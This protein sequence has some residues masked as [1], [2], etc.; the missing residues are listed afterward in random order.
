MHRRWN[1]AGLAPPASRYSHA[2]LTTGASRW[3]HL[4]GQLG[5]RP[6]GSLPDGLEGQL[7]QAF[8][9]VGTALADAGM[10]LSDL[11]R[12]TVYLTDASPAAVAAYRS[13]RD[14]WLAD[15]PAP[16]ATLLVV[17]GLAAPQF[18]VEVDAIAAA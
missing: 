10:G 15:A 18:L 13:R 3:L 16:A 12:L 1:P 9:N 4:S 2:V 11:V 14:L 5:L 17:A 8:A 7:D 6:D